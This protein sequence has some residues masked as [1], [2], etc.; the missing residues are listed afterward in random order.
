[1]SRPGNPAVVLSGFTLIELLVVIAI[2]ALLLGILLPGLRRAKQAAESVVCRAHLKGVGDG[3]SQYTAAW[4]QWIPGPSTSGAKIP[5][6]LSIKQLGRDPLAP[7]QNV[8]WMS[9]SLGDSLG[10]PAD[11]AERVLSLL[12]NELHCPSNR[13]KNDYIFG[14]PSI[15]NVDPKDVSY[16]SYSGLIA[17]HMYSSRNQQA[18]AAEVITDTQIYDRVRISQSYFPKIT[19]V[20]TPSSKVYVTEGARYYSATLGI[21]FNSFAWQDD[22][23]NFMVHGPVYPFSGDPFLLDRPQADP[24][25]WTLTDAAQRL[26]YRHNKKINMVFFDGHCETMDMLESLKPNFYFPRGT[27][28]TALG[29]SQM[30]APNVISEGYIQ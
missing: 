20:G 3:L 19:K 4:E 25:T 29:A 18:N 23:G 24:S 11:P 30:Q 8:D 21:S 12:N 7:T 1:M 9:P 27:Y 22:G 14:D 6:G 13:V 10:L 5:H 28:V 15:F 2:I 26:A 16:P 17:F